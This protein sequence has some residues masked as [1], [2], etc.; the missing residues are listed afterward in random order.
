MNKYEDIFSGKFPPIEFKFHDSMTSFEQF[1]K[2]NDL[3]INNSKETIIDKFITKN[4]EILT[5][6]LH[7]FETGNHKGWVFPKLTLTPRIEHMYQKGM[8]PDFIVGGQSSDGQDWWIVELKGA[9]ED[10]FFIDKNNRI[11][12]SDV[13][14]KG[15]C[16]LLE[17][18]DYASEKQSKLR[19][20]FGLKNFRE[21]KGLIIIGREQE[22]INDSRKQ[23]LKSAWNRF[24]KGKLEIRTYDFLLREF[25]Y[26]LQ[27]KN[28]WMNNS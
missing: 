8:I 12:F 5:T 4:P 3:I 18:I 9:N 15:V 20:D 1:Q 16:Q 14:N 28:E 17:Y 22:M 24:H 6:I 13:V 26:A 25:R 19:E 7:H 10:I 11:R 21:P 27:R 23:K 2:L